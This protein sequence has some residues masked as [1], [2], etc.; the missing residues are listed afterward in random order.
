MDLE[1]E[2]LPYIGTSIAKGLRKINIFTPVQLKD[3][4]P[5]FLYQQMCAS[6]NKKINPCLIDILMAAIYF[7]HGNPEKP[8]WEFTAQRKK[9]LNNKN[10]K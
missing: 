8:W 9:I 1:L 10:W 5:F 3:Q 7:V 2:D 4:N 6:A